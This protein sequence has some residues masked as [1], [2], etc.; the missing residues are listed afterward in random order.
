MGIT[1]HLIF[2]TLLVFITFPS[3]ECEEVINEDGILMAPG[4]CLKSPIKAGDWC[5]W[6]TYNCFDNYETCR[7][8]C[9][10]YP[11]RD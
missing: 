7:H 9:P 1:K 11:P 3:Y 6:T 4:W 10:P 8:K 2:F 5:C